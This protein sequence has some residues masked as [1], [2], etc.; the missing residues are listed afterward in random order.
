MTSAQAPGRSAYGYSS[1]N[2]FVD[3]S[4]TIGPVRD[5]NCGTRTYNNTDGY[6]HAGIDIGLWPFSWLAMQNEDVRI[7]AAGR[8]LTDGMIFVRL[9]GGQAQSGRAQLGG[10]RPL[11]VADHRN[12]DLGPDRHALLVSYQ[13]RNLHRRLPHK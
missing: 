13:C 12:V 5:Y 6:H 2:N 9:V 4:P 3:L 1:Q 11:L 8:D 7:V 10:R